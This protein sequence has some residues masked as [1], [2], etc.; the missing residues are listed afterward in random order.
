[1]R[2]FTYLRPT[3]IEEATAAL[4]E[5]GDE[6]RVIAG[7]QSLLGMMKMRILSPAYL[8]D[9]GRI[10]V[11]GGLSEANGVTKLGATTNYYT[12]ASATFPPGPLE[13]IKQ[14]AGQVGDMAM[15]N[16]GTIG[17][18]LCQA[19]PRSDFPV[20]ALVLGAELTAHSSRGSRVINSDAFFRDAYETALEPDELL[21]SVYFPAFDEAV[22]WSFQRFSHRQADHALA[23]VACTLSTGAEG[24]VEAARIYIG[25]TEST[26]VRAIKTE[27]V[28]LGQQF[29]ETLAGEAGLVAMEETEPL[30]D[31]TLYAP[32]YKRELVKTLTTRAL[33]EAYSRIM[34]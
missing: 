18:S 30:P 29:S 23:S 26:P 1:L 10:S 9:I 28:V 24:T 5:Y 2:P 32:D 34:R 25:S 6:A 17:G 22:G 15:R 14:V 19:D 11:L 12:A 20:V 3:S 8:V 33:C 16:M 27:Q 4:A 13:M 31:P 7:G 21:T